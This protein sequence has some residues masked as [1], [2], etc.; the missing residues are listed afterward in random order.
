MENL[1]HNNESGSNPKRTRIEVDV[2]NLPTDP[3]QIRRHYLQNKPC[4]PVDHDFPQSQFGKTKRQFNPVWFKDYP[5]W[6]EY[7]ITKDAAYCLFCYL[8]RP[9][10]GDQGGGDSF[11][12]EGF[13]NWKKKEKLQNHVGDH[14]SAHNIAQRKLDCICFLQRQGLA[15]RG[16][17]ESKDSNNQG[18]FL[19]LLRFL[20]N[21]NEEI[22]KAVLENA[23][24][25]HQMTSP[26]IQ[27]EIANVAAVE[28]INAIIK[29]IGDSLFAIIV[30]ESHDM[31]TKE[32][33]AI[34]LRYV[35]KLGHVNE[36][37]LGITHVNNTSAVTLKSAI[38]EVFNKH[39]LSISRLRGQGY[40]GASNMRGELN[41][42]KTLILKDN[43]SAYYV[44]CFA[45]QLQLTLVA[46]AK[47]HIQIA[48]FFNLVAKV[49][50]IVGA[51]CKRHDILHE[52]R[53]AEV[54]EALKNNDISTGRG[55]NQEM[56]LKRPGDTRWSSHYG[57]LV[58]IIHMFSSVIDVIETIIED[59]LDSD[60]RAEANILIGLLQTF[61]FVFDLHLMK[62]VLG[63]SNELSQALQR[64][65]QDIV[66][67][68]KL[69]DI[70]KQRLQVMRDDGWNSLL[71]E[72]SAFCEK[73]N[74]DVPDM[75]DFYQPR[76]R[77]KAQNMKNSHHYQV[78]LFYTVID[79][80]LQKLN[81]RFENS[82]LLLCVA[83][84]NPDNLFSAF[85]KE[86]L[87]RL[88]QFYPSDFS[89]V[90]VSF[91]DNQLET[92]I[93]DMRSSEEFSALKGIGQLAEKMVEMKKNVSYS[94]VYS[95]VTL[96]L[97]LPV[98]TATVERAFL[99]MN[100]I[101]N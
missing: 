100:I 79:M 91:L 71:E 18:N 8:L 78:E 89:T 49:F 80:Q 45:H 69:V 63:I 26:D 21:H 52:K 59:G 37:F 39:S 15:F 53:N 88:A 48:T 31:S 20:A 85:N 32:Q 98:T 5:S 23:P 4:Q 74:I 22:D 76:P 86:K 62:G 81:S 84:L 54:I 30:D 58:N 19:E 24:E 41:G 29:D 12:T 6:L 36:R 38:E 9:D 7:S 10:I 68:M 99:A 56:S 75:D 64:K 33:M 96:A 50:N 77:R 90:Q 65:D 34:A 25:Y 94:L 3:D 51:S 61:E 55:L 87:I 70:S 66:N 97:I 17:D 43:P 46:I 35:D 95:L 72:V 73:N 28:T 101:K 47:N 92:Y 16:H 14:N 27:K 13:R 82:E 93:H 83:C 40:D 42:L 57:A 60:Q 44:H 11:V 2:A 67:A 1:D